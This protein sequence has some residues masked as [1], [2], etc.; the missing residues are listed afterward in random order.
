M[1]GARVGE[2]CRSNP[3]HHGLPCEVRG[4][5]GDADVAREREERQ[6][7]EEREILYLAPQFLPIRKPFRPRARLFQ[8]EGIYFL[9]SFISKYLYPLLRAREKTELTLPPVREL[10]TRPTLRSR[11][12]L[13][14]VRAHPRRHLPGWR[15]GGRPI[16]GGGWPARGL[17]SSRSP[18][19]LAA[20]RRGERRGRVS[21]ADGWPAAG[22]RAGRSPAA[23]RG[24]RR[25]SQRR[26]R[27]ALA[28]AKRCSRVTTRANARVPRHF[29]FFSC[30]RSTEDNTLEIKNDSKSEKELAC[31]GLNF[32]RSTNWVSNVEKRAN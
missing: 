3:S 4:R 20:G 15:R 23:G 13:P 18:Q 24:Q 22:R 14:S 30:G 32:K 2:G 10:D 25:N 28:A 1:G 26:R 9:S 6:D 27:R 8:S 5:A 11:G 21:R 17:L 12:A 7:G 31:I 16:V 29:S 19:T